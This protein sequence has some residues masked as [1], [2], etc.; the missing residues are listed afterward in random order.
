[1]NTFPWLT[2]LGAVPLV[3]SLVVALLPKAKPTLAKQVALV[4]S[5]ITLGLTIAMALRFDSNSQQPF[6]FIE[7]V[8]WIPSFGISYSVG[9]DGIGLVLIALAT[10][11]SRSSSSPDGAMSRMTL[12]A[13]RG[14]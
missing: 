13:R 14:A 2:V 10:T 4:I 11:S 7:S 8:P 6:Q 3:G 1:M 12:P 9:V 5:L